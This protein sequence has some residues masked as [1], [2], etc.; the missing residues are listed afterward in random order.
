MRK[1][2]YATTVSFRITH[3]EANI[4]EEICVDNNISVSELYQYMTKWYIEN[5]DI[6]KFVTEIKRGKG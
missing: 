4:V 5:G 6:I 1:D 3:P 2:I